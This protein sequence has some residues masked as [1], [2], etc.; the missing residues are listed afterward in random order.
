MHAIT[1]DRVFMCDR[2]FLG[3]YGLK[4]HTHMHIHE[5]LGPM[6]GEP[7]A[8]HPEGGSGSIEG[9]G[10]GHWDHSPRMARVIS[11]DYGCMHASHAYSHMHGH[12]RDHRDH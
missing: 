7:L 1:G 2:L 3:T 9:F 11:C 12:T 5:R 4:S 6:D 10:M 8:T